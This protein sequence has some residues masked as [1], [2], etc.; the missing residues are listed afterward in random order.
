MK[1][2]LAFLKGGALMYFGFAEKLPFFGGPPDAD[3]R[4]LGLAFCPSGFLSPIIRLFS[5]LVKSLTNGKRSSLLSRYFFH[6][7]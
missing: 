3:T 1:A 4:G 2:V 5:A 6:I 7:N